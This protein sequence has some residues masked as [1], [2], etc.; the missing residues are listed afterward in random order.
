MVLPS[1]KN[2]SVNDGIDPVLL[3]LSYVCIHRSSII[4]DSII[5]ERSFAHKSRHQRSLLDGNYSPS[6][7]AI[8]RCTMERSGVY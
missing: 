7:S 1:P 6:G 2:F 8:A 3:S 5:G 4:F